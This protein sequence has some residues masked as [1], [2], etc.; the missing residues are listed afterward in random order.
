VNASTCEDGS[1]ADRELHELIWMDTDAA[2]VMIH[3][4]KSRYNVLLR[5]F[6]SSE[7][8]NVEGR[9]P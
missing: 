6:R 3:L 9:N 1:I 5:K 7:D 8:L 4:H 2:P